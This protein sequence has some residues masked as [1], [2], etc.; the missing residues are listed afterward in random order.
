MATYIHAPFTSQG[1]PATGLT[2]TIYAYD[3]SDDSLAVNG[4]SM[5]ELA[6]G[7]YYY[8]FTGYDSSKNYAFFIDAGDTLDVPD[9]YVYGVAIND[10]NIIVGIFT[11]AG[12][13]ATGLTPDITINDLSDESVEVNAQDM[14]EVANGIYKYNFSNWDSDKD[15]SIFMDGGASLQ[16]IERYLFGTTDVKTGGASLIEGLNVTVDTTDYVGVTVTLV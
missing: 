10:E 1:S 7:R 14:S 4:A 15:Y 16:N 3:L 2:P 12:S 11:S 13:P 8:I 5:S 9:R 6:N